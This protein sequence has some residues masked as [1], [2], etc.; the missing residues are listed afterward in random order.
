MARPGKRSSVDLLGLAP[1]LDDLVT[2]GATV[3]QM[4]DALN[5]ALARAGHDARVSRAAV[6]RAAQRR[7][8]ALAV[9]RRADRVLD[10]L[11]QAGPAVAGGEGRLELV[12]ALLVESATALAAD[13]DTPP[14]PGALKAIATAMLT[15][16]KTGH[17]AD[18]R[19]AVAAARARAQAASRGERAARGQGLSPAAAAAIRAAIE[20]EEPPA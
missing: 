2:E 16:E 3:D 15:V 11:R 18:Q 7:E 19:D 10:V 9:K 20:Q 8:A 13:P 4:T 14:D 12:R 5:Q 17:L 1:V 6:G